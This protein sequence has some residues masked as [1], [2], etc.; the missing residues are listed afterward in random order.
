MWYIPPSRCTDCLDRL[1][2]EPLP[3]STAEGVTTP[4]GAIR[5]LY[6]VVQDVLGADKGDIV[7]VAEEM[8]ACRFRFPLRI[9]KIGRLRYGSSSNCWHNIRLLPSLSKSSVFGIKLTVWNSSKSIQILLF[10]DPSL[11]PSTELNSS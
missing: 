3:P 11:C 10:L 1:S 5:R 7:S 9:H 8:L 4:W 6:Q 2:L